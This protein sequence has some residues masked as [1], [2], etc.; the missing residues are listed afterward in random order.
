VSVLIRCAQAFELHS[1][2]RTDDAI[3]AYEALTR[4]YPLQPIPFEHLG[5]AC[6]SKGQFERSIYWF[7]RAI[8]LLPRDAETY[9]GRA[10]AYD[11]L[12]QL[13]DAL[14]DLNRALHLDPRSKHAY[15]SRAFVYESQAKFELAA[16]DCRTT[17]KLPPERSE[18]ADAHTILA[19]VYLRAKVHEEALAEADKALV[20]DAHNA[21]A[22]YYKALAHE[23]LGQRAEASRAYRRF[24]DSP[25]PRDYPSLKD[26]W[27]RVR[28]QLALQ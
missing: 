25:V 12:A 20:L 5:F 19:N 7:D 1:R 11:G 22:L 17:L 4:A 24:A 10:R 21:A 3:T 27:L 6:L 13:D 15:I 28:K 14:A 26:A 2:G 8:V 16:E 23:G 18:D 9:V